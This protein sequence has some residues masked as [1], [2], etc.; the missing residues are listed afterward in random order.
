SIL[1]GLRA[2]PV[3]LKFKSRETEC[4]QNVVMFMGVTFPPQ[5]LSI[6]TEFCEGGCLYPY[7][8]SKTVPWEQK[9]QFI[10]GIAL[11]ML[12]LHMEKVIHR[13]LA[14]RN[15]LLTAHL[16]PKVADFGMSREQKGDDA[17]QTQSIIGPLKWMAP[18]AIQQQVYSTK[19]DVFS[20]AVVVWEIVA[21]RDPWE[22]VNPV[23]AA[24][25]VSTKGER[26]SIPSDCEPGISKLISQC[27]EQE[28]N[29][30][31][32]F[33]E[34]VQYLGVARSDEIRSFES[35]QSNG[36][37]PSTDQQDSYMPVMWPDK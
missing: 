8:R 14:V 20:F 16:V 4:A 17:G 35:D 21:V 1:Q 34:I 32:S 33:K 15:I 10:Q 26:M 13:D 36:S 19:S 24:I 3:N 37:Q 2:H 23:E 27:W 25:N 12:H 30:R 18:E 28:T 5:P 29:A 22:G 7:L 9:F 31:P 6:V 11:G